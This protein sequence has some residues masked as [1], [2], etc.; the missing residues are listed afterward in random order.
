MN[1][2]P[3]EMRGKTQA[4]LQAVIDQAAAAAHVP[5][6]LKVVHFEVH[7]GP[8]AN[9]DIK[10]FSERLAKAHPMQPPILYPCITGED[11]VGSDP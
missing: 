8:L 3:V 11:D 4:E 6:S 1:G 9:I 10:A 2:Q 7:P 5:A